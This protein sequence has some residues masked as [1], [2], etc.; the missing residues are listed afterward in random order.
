MD[1]IRFMNLHKAKGLEG[2][3]VIWTNRQENRTFRE[4]AYRSGTCFYPC[5]QDSRNNPLWVGYGGSKD[6]IDDAKDEEVSEAIRLEYV[7]VTRARQ[8]VIFMDRYQRGSGNMFS[9]NYGL[10]MLRSIEE[11]VNEKDNQPASIQPVEYESQSIQHKT[12]QNSP[13]FYSDSPS[14]KEDESA[15]KAVLTEPEKG[16]LERPVG[17]VF[18]TV[19]HRV[20]EL[21]I[22]RWK[23]LG[24]VALQDPRVRAAIHQSVTENLKDIVE[25]EIALYETFLYEEAKTFCTWLQQQEWIKQ[26]KWIE[27]EIPFSYL[28]N[29]ISADAESS[30]PVWMHGT[31]DVLICCK[32]GTFHI[33]D[34]KSDSDERYPSEEAFETRLR[35]KYQP[36]I[37]AY[38]DAFCRIYH[39]L[40][41]QIRTSL[42]S[43]SQK[44]LK[45]GEKLRLRVTEL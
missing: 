41:E 1:A 33:L 31:A 3:I 2:N 8:A 28:D 36:Q 19:M 11:I 21:L 26:A 7:A 45:D 14:Q 9:E 10:D 32:D 15:G 24:T 34:Y 44:S 6:L 35:G 23:Q 40:P 27:T 22:T 5:I 29:P 12:R 20:F 37:Q 13:V 38:K 42:I 18:G 43:F 25:S 16:A 4:G 17:N 39:V 30:I